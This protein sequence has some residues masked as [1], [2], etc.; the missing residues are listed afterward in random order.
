MLIVKVEIDFFGAI[1]APGLPGSPRATVL[2]IDALKGPCLPD[3]SAQVMVE[4]DRGRQDRTTK[5]GLGSAPCSR[6]TT[7]KQHLPFSSWLPD[8][9]VVPPSF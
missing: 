2:Q 6:V 9:E 3:D 1:P 5:A 8:S 4:E 7:H